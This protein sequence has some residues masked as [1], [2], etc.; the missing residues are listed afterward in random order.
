MEFRGFRAEPEPD[1]R[2]T[3]RGLWEGGKVRIVGEHWR[4][5]RGKIGTLLK[6]TT[7]V[8]E[9]DGKR[10]GTGLGKLEPAR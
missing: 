7:G 6:F 10:F 1:L 8:V 4:A 2:A 5:K 3:A 9:V